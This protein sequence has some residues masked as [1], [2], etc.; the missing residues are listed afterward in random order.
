MRRAAFGAAVAAVAAAGGLGAVAARAQGTLPACGRFPVAE[1]THA[2]S[3]GPAGRSGSVWGSGPYTTDS[4]LCT[5]AR[6]AGMIGAEGGTV[7]AIRTAGQPKYD[8][9][10]RN[11]ITSR[12]W[13]RFDTSMVFGPPPPNL[14]GA[15][16]PVPTPGPTPT[17][18]PVPA[19][20]P[21]PTPLLPAPEV[22]AA[23]AG[24]IA[25]CSRLDPVAVE[26]VCTCAPGQGTGAPV[27]GSGPYLGAS[28]LCAAARHAEVIGLQGG[29]ISVI[30]VPP[31]TSYRASERNGIASMDWGEGDDSFIVNAN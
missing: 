2:C 30:R 5:A 18:A 28:D 11:G 1:A 16:G 14:A 7:F 9:S 19:P 24:T 21:A 22:A 8:G 26:T 25:A 4:D 23:P 12:S 10:V 27:W 29:T 20:T 15:A 13:G 3:C 6:H 17:P 31:L